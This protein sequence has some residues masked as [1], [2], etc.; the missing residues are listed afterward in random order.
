MD[1]VGRELVAMVRE[2]V[3]WIGVMSG[4]ESVRKLSG[5]GG[6]GIEEGGRETTFIWKPCFQMR[7]GDLSQGRQNRTVTKTG[8]RTETVVR[9]ACVTGEID[10][11]VGGGKG[12]GGSGEAGKK[13]TTCEKNGISVEGE[14]VF[15]KAVG[16]FLREE[17]R[18]GAF[19]GN[20]MLNLKDQMRVRCQRENGEDNR[21]RVLLVGA[22]QM[23]RIGVEMTRT[24]EDKVR[25]VGRVRIADYK[26]WKNTRKSWKTCRTGRERW[27]WW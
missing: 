20:Y 17:V 8:E 3:D 24:S 26:R 10:R 25:I 14:F 9:A 2:W 4:R 6:K 12:E 1:L 21:L 11:M 16:E 18:V 19:K 7:V 23:G 27:M 15:S 22:S 5:T 13:Q